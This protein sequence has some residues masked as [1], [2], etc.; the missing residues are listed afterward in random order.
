MRGQTYLVT[1]NEGDARA[2]WPG[3][4]EEVRVRAHCA[5]GL[6]PAVFGPD[7]ARLLFDSNLCRLRITATPNGN[8][9][10]NGK[11]AAGQCTKLWSY[12]ARSF[13]IWRASDPSRGYDSGEDVEQLTKA[14]PNALFNS[15]HD[16]T[17]LDSRSPAKGP[18]PERIT[19]GRLGGRAFAFI[20][21]ERIGG[22]MVYDIT[23]PT[24]P[25][26]ETYLNTR[27]GLAGDRGPEGLLLIPA[28]QSPNGK[29][30]L[31]VSHEVSSTTA[32]LR[33]NLSDEPRRR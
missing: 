4:N 30:M 6:D 12:G 9:N 33:I 13:S 19:L 11:N 23:D 24:N 29:P 27:D 28:H 16:N 31:V 15:G 25:A 14:L 21:L 3:F 22:V 8:D 20:G 5:A 10:D 7:A 17:T 26:F 2:D 32:V 18:E 1:A